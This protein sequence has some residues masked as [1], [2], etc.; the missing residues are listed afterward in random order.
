M[1]TPEID[2]IATW[3]QK[4]LGKEYL[5]DGKLNGK[6]VEE[7]TIPQNRGITTKVQLINYYKGL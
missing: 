5:V 3:G 2:K 7:L 6:D 4:F 1:K